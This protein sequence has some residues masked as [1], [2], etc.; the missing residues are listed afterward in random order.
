MM[1]PKLLYLVCKDKKNNHI[2]IQWSLYYNAISFIRS[3]S[4][5]QRY[6]L[7]IPKIEAN[8]LTLSL[9]KVWPYKRGIIHVFYK[10]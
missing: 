9:K 7:I 6:Y 10:F 2:H 3:D 8:P 4:D 5:S 1:S